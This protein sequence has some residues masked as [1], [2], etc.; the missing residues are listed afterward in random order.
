MLVRWIDLLTLPDGTKPGKYFAHTPNGGARSRTEAAIFK[1]QGVR[2]GWPDY[3]L[4]LPRGWYHGLVMELK[5]PS[6][7][8]PEK[9]QLEILDRL[10]KQG[11]AVAVAW[12][13]D[14][15]RR[16]IENYL[17]LPEAPTP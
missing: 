2:K 15:A 8:K 9:E 17:Q 4:Y 6:G 5:A 10:E 13:F 7:S 1:G 11:Y 14:H 12:G 3:T 16:E